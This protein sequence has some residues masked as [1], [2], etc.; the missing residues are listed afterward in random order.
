LADV[1]V[2]GAKRDVFFVGRGV[3]VVKFLVLVVLVCGVG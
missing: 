1:G 2:L 3:V